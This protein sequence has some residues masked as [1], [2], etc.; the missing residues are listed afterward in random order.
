MS[1][2]AFHSRRARLGAICMAIILGCA[3]L[4]VGTGS[5]QIAHEV[6]GL[7]VSLDSLSTHI[8]S[9][10]GGYWIVDAAGQVTAYGAATNYG[11]APTHLNMPVV[12]IVST[13]DGLGYWLVA[14]DGGVFAFGDAQ[15]G[16]NA[17]GTNSNG[18]VVGIST[19]PG[20]GT[21]GPAGP[22]GPSGPPG[23]TGPIGSTG[24]AGANGI[25]HFAEFYALNP[26]NN[27]A[28]VLPGTDVQFP[29]SGPTDASITRISA[30]TF[31]LPT[32]GTYQVTFQVSVTEA[33]QLVLAINGSEVAYT[34]VG[35]AT[36]TSQIVETTLV[37]TVAANSVISVRNPTANATALTI[38]PLAGGADPVSSSIVIDQVR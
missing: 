4:V 13:S 28:T 34:V 32:I 25:M 30:S 8:P 36:G 11:S 26:P 19:M 27:A 6:P 1:T 37:T 7:H 31:N 24:P 23:P 9:P 2:T 22:T 12:G 3:A 18:S 14:K 35:R 21:T 29:S 20:G 15:Y 33:G 38:T 5:T 16:G 10:S 17:I